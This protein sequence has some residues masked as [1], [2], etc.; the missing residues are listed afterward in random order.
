MGASPARITTADFLTPPELAPWQLAANPAG[1]IGGVRLTLTGDDAGTQLGDCYQQVPLRVLPPFDFGS[2]QPKLLYLLNPTAGLMDGDAQLVDLVAQGKTRAVVV[3]QSA[4]RIHPAVHGFCTQRWIL[5]VGPEAVLVV[6][7]GPAIPFAGCRYVQHIDIDLAA[8]AGLVWGD[9][10]LAGRYARGDNSEQFRFDI[11]VQHLTVRREGRLV[12]R[13]RFCWRGPWDES[14]A[15]WH[16]GGDPACGSLFV[17]SNGWRMEGG[18]WREKT[19]E[20]GG[21]RLEGEKHGTASPSTLHPATSTLHTPPTV[22]HAVLPT[23]AG[24]TCVRCHGSS[25]AVTAWVVQTALQSAAQMTT[26]EDT[27]PWLF[28]AHD[29]GPNHWFTRQ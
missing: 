20:G 12:F 8:G 26:T 22:L 13:D 25:E 24:D 27:T 28:P 16:F 14:A 3:G 18:E 23:A 1:R 11:L 19:V 6:L 21:R 5:R 2:G 15:N 9:I 29:L 7:P 4:T 10:W 17:T